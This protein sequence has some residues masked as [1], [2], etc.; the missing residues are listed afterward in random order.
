MEFE[1]K[2]CIEIPPT[3]IWTFQKNIKIRDVLDKNLNILQN[4]IHFSYSERSD[5]NQQYIFLS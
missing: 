2:I 4:Y 3:E 5:I 1:N